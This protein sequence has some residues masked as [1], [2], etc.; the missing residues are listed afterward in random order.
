MVNSTSASLLSDP[1]APLISCFNESI[2]KSQPS[3]KD[4]YGIPQLF[5]DTF[6]E[7][8]EV[9]KIPL[10]RD[11]S[12]ASASEHTGKLFRTVCWVT[13]SDTE[14]FGGAFR[15]CGAW[16]IGRYGQD[17]TDLMPESNDEGDLIFEERTSLQCRI[18]DMSRAE[19]LESSLAGIQLDN[20]TTSPSRRPHDFTVKLYNEKEEGLL[21]ACLDVVGILEVTGNELILHSLI[22]KNQRLSSFVSSSTA[23]SHLIDISEARADVLQRF[24][25]VLQGDRLA[26]EL[27]LLSLTSGVA[28]R[29]P[30]LVGPLTLNI[31]EVGTSTASKLSDLVADLAANAFQFDMSID[32]LNKSKLYPSHDGEDF[33]PGTLQLPT[34][35]AVILNE[36]ALSEGKLDERG[37]KN[38]QCLI[39]SINTQD[40]IFHFPFNEYKIP[41]DLSFIVLSHG[42]SLLPSAIS[43]PLKPASVWTLNVKSSLAQMRAYIARCRLQEV[44]I[45]DAVSSQVQEDFVNKRKQGIMTDQTDL[46]MSLALGKEIARSYNRRS[47]SW[48]DYLHASEL[49]KKIVLA[50]NQAS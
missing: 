40:L 16:H 34:D 45:S 13:H 24:E 37:V 25:E 28:I 14:I 43:I 47:M 26:A 20:T 32:N 29:S 18:L 23:S 1:I 15:S 12:M 33:S 7:D 6:E 49:R 19:D 44:D 30:V 38:V 11:L 17:A 48:E 50:D 36:S 39:H 21:H 41:M 35:S 10:L 22:T 2:L 42:K 3:A 4:D 46:S 8:T 27:T 5:E 9:A 31:R